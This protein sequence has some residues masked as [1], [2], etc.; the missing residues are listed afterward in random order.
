MAR[1]FGKVAV[2]NAGQ[3]QQSP[4][5]GGFFFRDADGLNV[6]DGRT[7]HYGIE[8]ALVWEITEGLVWSGSAAWS[9]QTYDFTRIVGRGEE[10]IVAGTEIDTAPEWLADA[11][12]E[13]QASER[14]SLRLSAEHVGEYFTDAGNTATYPGHTVL[15]LRAGYDVGE[16]LEV[17]AVAGNLTDERYASRADYA[18]G[19]ARYFPG[20]PISLTVGLRKRFARGDRP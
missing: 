18:F 7:E 9:R 2:S 1:Q 3:L 17:F 15:N 16:G 11:T 14:L 8:G 10:S 20:E 19:T 6:T 12:L 4:K 5:K 13:W